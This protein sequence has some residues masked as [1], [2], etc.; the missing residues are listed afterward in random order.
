[1]KSPAQLKSLSGKW[2]SHDVFFEFDSKKNVWYGLAGASLETRPGSYPL[3]LE[4][5]TSAG[6]KISFQREIRI[7]RARYLTIPLHVATKFTEPSPQQLEQIKHDQT[8]KADLFART[9]PE[10]EWS[11][12]FLPPVKA[13]VSD[14]FGTRRVFNGKV[15]STHQGLDYAVSPGTPIAAVNAGTVLLARPLYFEGDCVVLDH[16]QGLLTLYLHLSEIGV[17]E[18]EQV[19]RGQQIGSSG[20]TGRATGP[21]LHMA[22]RW[23]GVYL[24]PASLFKLQIP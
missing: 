9:T 24:D 17:K 5:A 14:V 13:A 8:V 21:H 3:A 20:G 1:M 4:G 19:K 15:Q 16:G 11:G 23:Q 2:L 22:V 6:Q 12:R 10:Q 18:G 7:S